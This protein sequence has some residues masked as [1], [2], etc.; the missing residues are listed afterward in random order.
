MEAFLLA[1]LMAQAS[2]TSP[3]FVAAERAGQQALG[4]WRECAERRSLDILQH[5]NQGIVIPGE[6]A[7]AAVNACSQ[8]R[9]EVEART[10]RLIRL[11]AAPEYAANRADAAVNE[12][13]RQLTRHVEDV[14]TQAVNRAT[15]STPNPQPQ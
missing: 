13:R 5:P 10:Y 4:L 1:V 2:N 6:I 7:E 9:G 14:L 12:M 8:E 11:V 15:A 3:E